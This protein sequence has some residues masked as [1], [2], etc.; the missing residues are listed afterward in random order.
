MFS[1]ETHDLVV[2]RPYASFLAPVT[3]QTLTALWAHR[4]FF[5]LP[6]GSHLPEHRLPQ[7]GQF[8]INRRLHFCEGC[9]RVCLAP[10]TQSL[11]KVFGLICGLFWFVT[12]PPI[13]IAFPFIHNF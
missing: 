11:R 4:G 12:H 6:L 8:S 13:V 3:H 2:F 7:S 1:L 10:A 9:F 5:A